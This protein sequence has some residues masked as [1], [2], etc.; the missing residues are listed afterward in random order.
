MQN[1]DGQ[2]PKLPNI[3]EMDK[4]S[5][6]GRFVSF[7]SADH[8]N[9][10]L[11]LQTGVMHTFPFYLFHQ[12]W[13][14]DC[15]AVLVQDKPSNS[16]RTLIMLVDPVTGEKLDLSKDFEKEFGS[17]MKLTFVAP[18]WTPDGKYVVLYNTSEQSRA[19]KRGCLVQLNPFKIVLEKN[20]ILRWSPI[21]G[22]VLTQGDM[23]FK[24]IDY[25]G[26]RTADIS[27][28]PNDWKWSHDG[29]YAA[30]I[31]G[32]KIK[33]FKPELPPKD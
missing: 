8:T 1:Q 31:S 14:P 6:N 20:Q 19:L 27:G 32:H 26:S 17:H 3:N 2:L 23:T 7:W 29:S 9:A 25:A 22:W 15:T 13:K 16:D 10:L 28:W 4:W 12:C 11:D 24:W 30:M 21:A 5:P 33:I 18:V